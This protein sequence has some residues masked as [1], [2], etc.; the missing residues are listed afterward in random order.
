MG[1]IETDTKA[2]LSDWIAFVD[3]PAAVEMIQAS[4]AIVFFSVKP[5]ISIITKYHL[6]VCDR[7][8]GINA[9]RSSDL[10]FMLL[11]IRGGIKC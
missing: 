9:F 2:N 5:N 11:C 1:L 3:R 8:R 4:R 7:M 10:N 6:H